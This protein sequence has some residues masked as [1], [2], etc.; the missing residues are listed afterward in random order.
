MNSKMLLFLAPQKFNT[1][2]TF[3]TFHNYHLASREVLTPGVI[4]SA[5]TQSMCHSDALAGGNSSCS[6]PECDVETSCVEFRLPKPH[7][8]DRPD[9][10]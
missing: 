2:N 8:Y 10:H 3:A 1:F 5:A 4:P 9:S 6:T 7:C